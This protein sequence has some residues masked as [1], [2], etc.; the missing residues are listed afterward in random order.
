[1]IT[2]G[3]KM[4]DYLR[5]WL[6]DANG[7]SQPVSFPKG[8]PFNSFLRVF[9]RNKRERIEEP[10]FEADQEVQ[11]TVPSFPGKDPYSFN[12][13]PAKARKQFA[14][15]IREYFDAE[16]FNDMS[17]FDIVSRR[18]QRSELL[19]LWME[20]HGIEPTDKNFCAVNKRLQLLRQRATDRTRKR[21][22]YQKK[23]RK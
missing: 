11:I 12:W 17:R 18:K 15:L 8:S 23:K 4:P 1:M 6:V 20:Q 3:L 21:L 14:E 22:E 19:I 5:Q 10:D 2:I 9:L 7:G 13:L 16:L